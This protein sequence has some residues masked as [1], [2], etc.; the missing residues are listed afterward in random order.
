M[1]AELEGPDTHV[2]MVRGG[3]GEIR[4]SADGKDLFNGPRLW[5]PKIEKVVATVKAKLGPGG[6]GSSG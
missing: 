6:G 4:V 2:E 1:A 3:L 5:Y